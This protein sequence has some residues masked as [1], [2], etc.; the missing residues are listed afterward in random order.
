MIGTTLDVTA[1]RHAEEALRES[2]EH[3]RLA[4]DAAEMAAWRWDIASGTTSWSQDLQ[5]ILGVPPSAGYP[6]FREM[7]IEED[8]AAFLEV[9]RA[10]INA[11]STYEAEFRIR[12]TDGA[13][14]WLLARGNI[15][16]DFEG[17]AV[18]VA[19]V[20]QDV[21]RRKLAEL[22]L[23]LHR[24]R[25][26]SLVDERTVQLS[27]AKEAAESANVAKSAFLANMSHEIRTP[28]NG[29]L[30]MVHILRRSELTAKQRERLDV[31]DSAANHLLGILNDVLD[32]S[33]IEAGKFVID[34]APLSVEKL[35]GRVASILADGASR[36][37]LTSSLTRMLSTAT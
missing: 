19:G 7:V 17:R 36:K 20:T 11:G 29:I 23:D 34:E 35:L 37:A 30:G 13:V 24:H 26:E 10:A 8:R 14:R 15:S 21:T 27:R 31:I 3:M 18:S 25:L 6:N 4:L 22:D 33:K 2:E 28:M 9:G 1:R 12:R 5:K 32:I 16:R